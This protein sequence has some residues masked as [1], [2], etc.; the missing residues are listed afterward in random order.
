MDL[1]RLPFMPQGEGLP[2]MPRADLVEAADLELLIARR[3][4]AIAGDDPA[5]GATALVAFAGAY[6]GYMAAGLSWKA[7]GVAR[8]AS[9]LALQWGDRQA[10]MKA[11]RRRGGPTR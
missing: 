6:L 11:A 5:M 2:M 8:L 4:A 7:R 1:G 9:R 3:R 10:A